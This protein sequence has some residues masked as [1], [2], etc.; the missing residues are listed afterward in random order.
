MQ[1]QKQ[2]SPFQKSNMLIL[3]QYKAA[4]ILLNLY[5]NDLA[6]QMPVFNKSSS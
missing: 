5:L 6:I 4:F 2:K 3:I 1:E